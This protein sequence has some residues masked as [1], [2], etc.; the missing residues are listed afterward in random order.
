MFGWSRSEALGKQLGELI[1]PENHRAAHSSGLQRF[2]LTG[3]GPIL[4]RRLEIEAQRHDGTEIKVELSITAFERRGRHVF[5]SFIRDLTD[6]IAAETKL[7][8]AQKMEAVGQLTGGVAHYFNNI[9][10]VITDTIEIFDRVRKKIPS[11]LLLIGDG[12]DRSRAGF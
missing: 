11:R 12:P 10:T 2:L 3:E 8:Q 4:G 1:I 9:L 5:N 6:K 7:R